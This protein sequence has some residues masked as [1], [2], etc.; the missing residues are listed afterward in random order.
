MYTVKRLFS[1]I[2]YIIVIFEKIN[3][4]YA[5]IM[6][7]YVYTCTCVYMY[8]MRIQYKRETIL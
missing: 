7:V 4:V 8:I 1:Q 5:R 2:L 3:F 6:R